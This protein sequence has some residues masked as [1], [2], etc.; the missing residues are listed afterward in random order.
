MDKLKPCPFCGCDAVLHER[1]DSIPKFAES[2]KEIQRD[3]MIVRSVKYPSSSLMYEYREKVYIPQCVDTSCIGRTTR[4]F[5]TAKE[6][7]E[8]WN[9]RAG[10]ETG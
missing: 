9:R 8:A 7:I 6:A 2:K 10:N 3:A 1:Y 5:K 4:L